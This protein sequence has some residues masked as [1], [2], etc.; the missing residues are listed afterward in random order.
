KTKLLSESMRVLYVALTRA[1]QK[2]ILVGS[3]KDKA[4]ALSTWGLVSGHEEK[5]LPADLRLGAKSFMD[6]IG[7]SVIRHGNLD[8]ERSIDSR[9]THIHSYDTDF[10]VTFYKQ[11]DLT[12]SLLTR[13]PEVTNDWYEQLK[14][15]KVRE[16]ENVK[17]KEAVTES[18]K[19]MNKPYTFQSATLT[20]SYQSV[21]E[22]KRLFEEPDDG[23]MVKID[24]TNPRQ[25][26]RY[27]EDELS[28]PKF[29]SETAKP[30]PAEIGQATHLVLQTLDLHEQPML[31]TVND[32]IQSLV[33]ETVLTEEMGELIKSE[34]I[35]RFFETEFGAFI[36][37]QV[38]DMKR[39]VPFSLLMEAK[40]IFYDMEETDDNILIHGI[41]D[42][43]IEQ[44]D[45]IIL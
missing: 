23:Q 35:V 29:I 32:L 16:E 22:I 31:E 18:L 9:N 39:E 33:E 5:E 3:Y 8:D 45:G 6:W 17:I 41:V 12:E 38:Q 28:R 13:Q 10:T 25:S 7:M 37:S 19:L 34:K 36:L 42:G 21:S 14:K 30:T 4:K 24:I 20:T 2:L 11:S 27:V 43:F 40:E 1:E 44:E 26:N 15:G